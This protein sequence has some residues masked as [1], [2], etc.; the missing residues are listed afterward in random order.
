VRY[1]DGGDAYDRAMTLMTTE[2]HPT[3]TGKHIIV[4][5]ADRKIVASDGS[6]RPAQEKVVRLTPYIGVGFAGLSE[7]LMEAGVTRLSD[8]FKD[9]APS[10]E[11][12]ESLE[13]LACRLTT[14]LNR[15]VPTER[16]RMEPSAIH[17]SGLDSEGRAQFWF[18]RNIDDEK[19]LTKRGYECRE[20]FQARDEPN[21]APGAAQIYRNGDLYVHAA[22]WVP[23]DEALGGLLGTEDFARLESPEQYVDWVRFK[24]KTIANFYECFAHAPTIGGEIDAFC[25]TPIG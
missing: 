18:I 20:D 25:I 21:L 13:A 5:A 7:L 17:L 10:I 9:I 3:G 19:R 6:E 15:L 8:W 14:E 22:L 24:M 1:L 4:F 12:T 23:M 2:I 11:P 16:H